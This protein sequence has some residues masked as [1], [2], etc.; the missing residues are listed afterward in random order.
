MKRCLLFCLLSLMILSLCL[1]SCDTSITNGITS[2]GDTILGGDAALGDSTAPTDS[3]SSPAATPYEGTPGLLFAE[4]Y[5]ELLGTYCYVVTGAVN[6]TKI[7]HL[8]IPST[9]NGKPVVA[10]LAA[11]NAASRFE[12]VETVVLPDTLQVMSD[13]AF[14]GCYYLR[15]IT[16]PAGIQYIGNLQ[17]YNCENLHTINYRGTA[18]QWDSVEKHS[19]WNFGCNATVIFSE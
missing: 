18:A 9:F 13:F 4:T 7:K 12:A 15:S 14:Y 2:D 17:F 5:N 10:I 3:T 8:V 11:D 1:T 6:A 16:I 19:S